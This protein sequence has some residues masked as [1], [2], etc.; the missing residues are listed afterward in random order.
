MINSDRSWLVSL[1]AKSGLAEK[2][3]S[4]TFPQANVE[5]EEFVFQRYDDA[6]LAV[7]DATIDLK[8][9]YGKRSSAKTVWAVIGILSFGVAILVGVIGY[10]R[11]A[12]TVEEKPETL[13]SENMSPFAAIS[14]LQDIYDSDG[15]SI[16]RKNEL[17]KTITN[18]EAH[19]FGFEHS[20]SK[21]NVV[22]E[23]QKW[24]RS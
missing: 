15:I 5:V 3:S 18:L 16:E 6:D 10:W 12:P 7:A 13:I 11:R 4:F 1:E 2:P 8:A 19:Y 9:S 17:A 24:T 21:P 14:L 22:E 23:L 20:D